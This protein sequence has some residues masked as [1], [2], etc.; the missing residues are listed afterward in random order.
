MKN[1]SAISLSVLSANEI[2][3]KEILQ[4]RFLNNAYNTYN[5][6]GESDFHEITPL[7]NDITSQ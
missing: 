3:L 2:Q 5:T 1:K 6:L 4:F 7:I